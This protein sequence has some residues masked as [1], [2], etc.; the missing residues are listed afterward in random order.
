MR[1]P[2]FDW[3]TLLGVGYLIGLG[4]RIIGMIEALEQ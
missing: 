1:N 3:L 4:Y 2:I